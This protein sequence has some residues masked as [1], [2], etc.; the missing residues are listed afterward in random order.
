M[1]KEYK[2]EDLD[3]KQNTDFE[4]LQ[5][6]VLTLMSVAAILSKAVINLKENGMTKLNKR[7]EDFLIDALLMFEDYMSKLRKETNDDTSGS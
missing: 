7:Q 2:E 4:D 5:M 6:E 3:K 1:T